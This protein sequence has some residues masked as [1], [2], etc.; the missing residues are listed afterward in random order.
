MNE[1]K[2]C[3]IRCKQ[4]R[5]WFRSQIV[6]FEDAETFLHAVMYKNTEPCPYCDTMVSHDKEIMRFVEKDSTGKVIKETR[7]IYDF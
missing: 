2:S 1:T 4:C 6:Q 7:C 3:E 5:K